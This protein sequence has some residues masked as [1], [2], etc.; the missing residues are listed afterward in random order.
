MTFSLL[1]YL[2]GAERFYTIP[3][4]TVIAL[5]TAT[6]LLA[7]AIALIMSVP[8]HD[9]MLLL[10]E[11]SGAGA[12]ARITLPGLLLLIP[13]V[14]WLRV[15]GYEAGFYD[16]GTGLALVA[17]ALMITA[18]A[19]LWVALRIVRRHEQ[20]LQQA[21]RRKDLFLA[22]LA[23]E[24]RN[25]LAPLRNA[26]EVQRRAG[27]D[28]RIIETAR[29]TMERQVGQLVRLVDDLLDTSRIT[30]GKLQLEKTRVALADVLKI[31]VETAKPLIEAGKQELTIQISQ[32][33]IFVHA[34]PTRLAQVF[35]N[36]LNNSAK[37]TGAGGHIWLT[38]EALRGEA[39][40]TVRDTGIGIAKT[41]LARV[42]DLFTQAAP[43]LER[44]KS[45]LG[46]GL[47]LVKGIVERHGGTIEATSSGPG[48]GSEFIVRLPILPSVAAADAC[49]DEPPRHVMGRR[50]VVVDDL[51]DAADSLAT[52]LR[53]MGHEAR[54]AYDG[55]DAV[56]VAMAFKP[57][58][59]FL[60]IGLPKMNGYE[61]ARSIR[62]QL[63]AARV[64][65]VALTGWGQ[66][67]DRRNAADAGFDH[68]LTKPVDPHTVEALIASL[69]KTRAA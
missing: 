27:G 4:L 30:A 13:V 25:P 8:E 33:A 68:H 26:I 24:L 62:A 3:W 39:V 64:I 53:M 18:T 14:L 2:F 38:A 47:S 41:D 48:K 32:R 16:L 57:E 12:L 11:S 69:A 21:D 58:V 17:V 5:P 9:P 15:R 46:I 55:A 45:G 35:A 31:A 36:L 23:H 37:Y 42:F 22:T 54:T 51:Q 50:I 67:H 60:D 59:V 63:G 66:E 28:L 52:M 1:G 7:I 6:L 56:Q 10:R 65:L 20:T 43:G 19:G 49:A 44:S 40:I 61:A 29:A 34:D